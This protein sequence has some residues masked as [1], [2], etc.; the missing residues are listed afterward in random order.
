MI[1]LRFGLDLK[2]FRKIRKCN[3]TATLLRILF[4]YLVGIPCSH[5]MSLFDLSWGMNS[6]AS[7]NVM[8]ESSEELLSRDA[9]A[10]WNVVCDRWGDSCAVTH[11]CAGQSCWLYA[12]YSLSPACWLVLIKN[13]ANS[14]EGIA[15]LRFCRLVRKFGCLRTTIGR[16]VNA[17]R[18]FSRKL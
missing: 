2:G 5:I 1:V 6:K 9:A 10:K 13:P 4:F 11:C 12:Y 3:E 15:G 8:C 14:Q 17:A 16:Q 7:L 18:N